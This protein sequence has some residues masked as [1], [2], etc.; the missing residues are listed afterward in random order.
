MHDQHSH[1]GTC[2]LRRTSFGDGWCPTSNGVY[3]ELAS[4]A[5]ALW[6]GSVSVGAG[7][8]LTLRD[9]FSQKHGGANVTV[10]FA[11]KK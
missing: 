3:P 2:F 10:L 5:G 8:N 11:S 1:L 6:A 7:A 4:N 9:C